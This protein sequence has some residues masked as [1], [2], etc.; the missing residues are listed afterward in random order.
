MM[1]TQLQG[2]AA[3]QGNRKCYRCKEIGCI[4]RNCP[5]KKS[6]EE[7]MHTMTGEDCKGQDVLERDNDKSDSKTEEADGV[8]V[9]DTLY[10]FGQNSLPNLSG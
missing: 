10:F 1:F 6:P 8:E 5:A 7:Q 3:K 9:D 4:L 2:D